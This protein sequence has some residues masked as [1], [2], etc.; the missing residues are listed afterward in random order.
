VFIDETWT[1]TNMTR[2]HGR[3]PKGERLR[4]GLPNRA[5]ASSSAATQKPASIVF[6]SR[7]ASTL[8]VAQSMIATK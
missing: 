5:S 1:A 2:S 7:H 3:C 8:R 4:M 6:D